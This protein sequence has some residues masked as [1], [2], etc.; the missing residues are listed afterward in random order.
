MTKNRRSH[1]N[2]IRSA[3]RVVHFHGAERSSLS[4]SAAQR[5]FTERSVVPFRAAQRSVL[6]RSAERVVHF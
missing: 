1:Q 3:E 6:S 5:A 2:P 4:R